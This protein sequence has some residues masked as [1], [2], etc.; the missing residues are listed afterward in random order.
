[1]SRVTAD[2]EIAEIL[3]ARSA[4]TRPCASATPMSAAWRPSA[5]SS[6]STSSSDPTAPTSPPGAICEETTG[7][8]AW[9]GSSTPSRR[10]LRHTPN[11]SSRSR[12]SRA[13][14]P[15]CRAPHCVPKSRSQTP[16]QGCRVPSRQSKQPGLTH[17]A[18]AHGPDPFLG[19][20]PISL[21]RSGG[22]VRRIG[23]PTHPAPRRGLEGPPDRD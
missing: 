6:L 2:A 12:S 4:T 22:T 16:T 19:R 14:R 13:T 20:T 8:S 7:S 23:R 3:C 11:A 17:A 9:T 5:R 21:V 10:P 1:M 15:D 18:G